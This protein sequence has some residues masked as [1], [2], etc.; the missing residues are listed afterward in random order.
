MTTGVPMTSDA[1]EF[2]VSIDP[3][4]SSPAPMPKSNADDVT[5]SPYALSLPFSPTAHSPSPYFRSSSTPP[6]A[7][8]SSPL[9]LLDSFLVSTPSPTPSLFDTRNVRHTSTENIA[10]EKR[11]SSGGLKGG[12]KVELALGVITYVAMLGLVCLVYK[13][14][15]DNIQRSRYSYS[16]WE[17][18]KSLCSSIFVSCRSVHWFSGEACV[19]M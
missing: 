16:P 13:K 1:V 11:E 8:E 12:R 17:K 4:E 9:P 19:T 14:R 10:G 2:V 3:P 6:L 5:P 7:L 15:K 18:K